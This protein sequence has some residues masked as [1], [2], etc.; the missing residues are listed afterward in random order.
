M[1]DPIFGSK[2]KKK[3]LIGIEGKRKE[4]GE[5]E[6]DGEIAVLSTVCEKEGFF[7]HRNF[8]SLPSLFSLPELSLSSFQERETDKKPPYHNLHH[9]SLLKSYPKFSAH[10]RW[11]FFLRPRFLLLRSLFFLASAAAISSLSDR[12][13]YAARWSDGSKLE[14]WWRST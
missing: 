2:K 3:K 11:I 6:R 13:S 10:R 12:S 5:E 1:F 8:A 4:K 7:R 14:T 9:F